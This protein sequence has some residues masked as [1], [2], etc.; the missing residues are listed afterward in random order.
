MR[1]FCALFSRLVFA[2]AGRGNAVGG[3]E[4]E[5]ASLV[6]AVMGP[7]RVQ[8]RTYGRGLAPVRA[9]RTLRV[10]TM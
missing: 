5:W 6:C 10:K 4:N 3:R 8:E 1:G 2:A 9:E 7:G